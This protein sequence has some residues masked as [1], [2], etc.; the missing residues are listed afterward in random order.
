MSFYASLY[1]PLALHWQ[2]SRSLQICELAI[3]YFI[4]YHLYRKLVADLS[5]R[6]KRKRNGCKLPAKVFTWDPIFGLDNIASSLKYLQENWALD[7]GYRTF[8]AWKKSTCRVNNL[9]QDI[10][11]TYEA[12]NIK[13]M[14]ATN[15]KSWGIG[16][17][18]KD[19]VPIFGK[20]IFT[21][22]GEAW[23]HSRNMLRPSFIRSQV[24]DLQLFDHHV[25]HFIR[26]IPRDGSTIDL[27]PLFYSLTLDTSTEFLFG[28]STNALVSENYDAGSI[29][30][31]EAFNRCIGSLHGQDSKFGIWSVFL[32]ATAQF[33][34]DC[35]TVHGK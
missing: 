14:L 15:F 7:V 35:R 1:K 6:R 23:Q 4:L 33:K 3:S 9:G 27:Q 17:A 13:T 8:T 22:D 32:P 19:L 30:F 11:F 21:T 12:E 34:R 31:V 20:G 5:L 2:S 24:A 26:A 28:E 10:I 16:E 25:A 29:K 18:R